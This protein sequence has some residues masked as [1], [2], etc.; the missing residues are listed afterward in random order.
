M[1]GEVY[2]LEMPDKLELARRKRPAVINAPEGLEIEGA[3]TL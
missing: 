1:R 2:T 3:C